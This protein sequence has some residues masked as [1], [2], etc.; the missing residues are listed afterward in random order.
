MAYFIDKQSSIP[1]YR[2]LYQAIKEDIV[3]QPKN[4]APLPSIRT[5]AQELCLSINTVNQA[6]QQLL[7][8]GYIYSIPGSGYYRNNVGQSPAPRRSRCLPDRKRR[9]QEKEGTVKYNFQY[10]NLEN[11]S[12]PWPKWKECLKEAVQMEEDGNQ[13]IYGD[14]QGLYELREAIADMLFSSRGVQCEPEQIVICSGLHDAFRLMVPMLPPKS[15][16][17]GIEEPGYSTGRNVFQHNS[18]AIHPLPV[19]R[20]GISADALANSHCNL[21]YLTPSHQYPTGHILP[22]AS[23]NNILAY[24]EQKDGFIIEDDYDSMFRYK[25]QPIPP[26][27]SLDVND[28]V[29]YLGTF[30]KL[31]TPTIRVAYMVLPLRLL[32]TYWTTC[33]DY[34]TPVAAMIQY[35]L[36]LFMAKGYYSCHVRKVVKACE[37]KYNRIIALFDKG[38]PSCVHPIAT[39]SGVHLM[40]EFDT[41]LSETELLN[42]LEQR[43]IR[44]YPTSQYWYTPGVHPVMLQMGFAAMDINEIEAGLR[45][46]FAVLTCQ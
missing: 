13:L 39:G 30:S 1:L 14:K 5:T 4:D 32:D 25:T 45:H 17:L 11:R 24:I 15:Y 38:A 37:K 27:Y 18:Y 10:G 20:A 9:S 21:I 8:E 19:T 34:K 33:W 43:D 26:L 44:L 42:Y 29:I 36:Y 35:A 6:Y 12:F 31:F 22:I 41:S 28:R 23:R 3:Q 40:L 7:A 2:Q 16:Q 46:L